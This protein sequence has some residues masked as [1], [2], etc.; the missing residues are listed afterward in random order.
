MAHC[1]RQE[2]LQCC[3][4]CCCCCCCWPEGLTGSQSGLALAEGDHRLH[5]LCAS[6][7]MRKAGGQ[8]K[9][10]AGL[11]HCLTGQVEL[12]ISSLDTDVS[13]CMMIPMAHHEHEGLR[14]LLADAPLLFHLAAS[15]TP[16]LPP[17]PLLPREGG[18]C[19]WSG[20]NLA[21]D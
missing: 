15:S 6:L 1:H 21:G 20:S 14:A 8:V 5:H 7:L 19:W 3:C 2:L 12:P 16:P 4:C 10:S 9:I 11:Y 18:T 13:K 17:T